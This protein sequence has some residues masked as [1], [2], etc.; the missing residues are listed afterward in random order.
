MKNSV[1]ALIL[2]LRICLTAFLLCILSLFLFSFVTVTRLD[3]LWQQLGLN[4][5]QGTESIY[6][7]FTGG[8]LYYYQA[9]NIKHIAAGNKV[10]IAKDLMAYAKQYVSSESFKKQYDLERAMARPVQEALKPIRTKAQIQKD[11][12]VKTE[13]S[14]KD[15]E[16][17]M[18]GMDAAMQKNMLPV[19]DMF[20]KMLR[21]YQD[22]NHQYFKGL[23]L[24]EAAEKDRAIKSY[25]EAVQ[26]WEKN[27]P[28]N[29]TL[30]IKER[31][32]KFLEVT[33]DVDFDAEL[34]TSYNKKVFVKPAYESKP[35]EWKQAFRAGKEV[36]TMARAFASQW[37]SELK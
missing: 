20:K 12:I 33:K 27:Y 29:C 32:Q 15:L 14:I 8:Y 19:M 31:L 24:Y 22:P 28:D 16:K 25:D 18:K 26:N 11:E 9:R 17:N 30:V 36:T 21:E 3:D 7:S 35:T 23:L 37:L 6:K 34:K 5:Q 2:C 13:K 10:A 4:K 1:K